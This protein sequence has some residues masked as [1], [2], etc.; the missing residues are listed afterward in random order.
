MKKGFYVEIIKFAPIFLV[1]FLLGE[2][3]AAV[4]PQEFKAKCSTPRERHRFSIDNVGVKINKGWDK[5]DNRL[6]ASSAEV[7][8]RTRFTMKGFKKFFKY[9][10]KRYYIHIEDKSGFSEVDDFVVIQNGEGHE[11]TYPLNCIKA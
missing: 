1:L 11:I 5:S 4:R 2:L 9:E 10:N 7:S 6:P 8:T 3:N